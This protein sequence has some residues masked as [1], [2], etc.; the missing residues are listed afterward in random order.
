MKPT[1]L[2]NGESVLSRSTAS[3]RRERTFKAALKIHGGSTLRQKPAMD[4]LFDTMN[5]KF[6][7]RYFKEYFGEN[8]T[9]KKH[10]LPDVYK[11]E[12]KEF[13]GSAT[14]VIRSIAVYYSAGVLGKRKYQAVRIAES[15]KPHPKKKGKMT[16]LGVVKGCNIPKLLTY[17]N[18]RKAINNDDI[19]HVYSVDKG[20]LNYN[21]D[22]AE[23]VSGCYR[24]LREYLPKLAQF[25]LNANEE[26][27]E[28]LK[29]F[30][31]NK[32]TFLV[33]LGGDG[34]PFGKHENA[35][36]FLVNFINI[37]HRVSSSEENFL[38][39][40]GNCDEGIP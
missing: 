18:L 15:M 34:C 10:V 33:A 17:A 26:R 7:V 11:R 1:S 36:S 3:D 4:G 22:N 25:Y 39:F 24:D 2:K 27:K 8:H 32:N 19:G 31:E 37:G 30:S 29:W 40:G 9:I 13:E 21:D 35:C 28:K 12:L 5:K 23:K 38:V 14:N 16:S 20:E 6:T